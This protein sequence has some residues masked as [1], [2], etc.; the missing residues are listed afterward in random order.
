[1]NLTWRILG[2]NFIK[3]HLVKNLQK[4][5]VLLFMKVLEELSSVFSIMIKYLLKIFFCMRKWRTIDEKLRKLS[6]LLQH[7]VVSPN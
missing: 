7:R 2:L 5:I 3:N 6:A 4:K 1:M